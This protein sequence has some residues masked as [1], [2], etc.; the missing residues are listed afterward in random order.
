MARDAKQDALA[1]FAELVGD[2]NTNSVLY[3]Y[4]SVMSGTPCMWRGLSRD[5]R[6]AVYACEL[7]RR[8]VSL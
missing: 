4:K 3:S 1:K 5:E 6:E 2:M 8:G 7:I